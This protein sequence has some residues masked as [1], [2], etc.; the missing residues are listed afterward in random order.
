M[1]LFLFRTISDETLDFVIHR[2]R[3]KN[4]CPDSDK[5]KGWLTYKKD[6]CPMIVDLD[7]TSKNIPRAKPMMVRLP[8]YVAVWI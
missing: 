6:N 2:C 7:P 5:D 1:C 4:E 8:N 3:K